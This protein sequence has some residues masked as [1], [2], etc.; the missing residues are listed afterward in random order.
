VKI[1]IPTRSGSKRIPDKNVQMLCRDKKWSLLDWAIMSAR[2]FGKQLMA[3]TPYEI[4]VDSDSEE[5]LDSI[6]LLDTDHGFK[7]TRL[8]RPDEFA[9]DDTSIRS[10]IDYHRR[11]QGW[12][13][14]VLLWQTT[15]PFR[16]WDT[17]KAVL[18][19]WR[20]HP[21]AQITVA[22]PLRTRFLIHSAILNPDGALSGVLA[23][24]IRASENNVQ[25]HRHGMDLSAS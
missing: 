2:L 22:A 15:N 25:A 20:T 19:H 23:G 9:T 3:E 5:Y 6:G 24:K 8:H 7:V 16:A 21:N 1:F 17:L 12:T 18:D 4:V 13:D 14:A 10:V 11:E